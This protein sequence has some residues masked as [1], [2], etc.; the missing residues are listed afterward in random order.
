MVHQI[1][2]FDKST[3]FSVLITC[4]FSLCWLAKT[5]VLFIYFFWCLIVFPVNL[6]LSLYLIASWLKCFQAVAMPREILLKKVPFPLP[7]PGLF[8]LDEINAYTSDTIVSDNGWFITI[9]ITMLLAFP[10][11]FIACLVVSVLASWIS[12]VVLILWCALQ[13]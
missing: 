11:I 13:P 1:W 7:R 10:I 4:L 9:R 5:F 6:E 8:N 12:Q 2:V 3:L